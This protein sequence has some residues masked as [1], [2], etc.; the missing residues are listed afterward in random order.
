MGNRA[1]ADEE[2]FHSDP[3][4]RKSESIWKTPVQRFGH[5]KSCHSLIS[6]SANLLEVW[7]KQI[8]CLGRSLWFHMIYVLNRVSICSCVYIY[9][10]IYMYICIHLYI[11]F[12]ALDDLM[13]TSSLWLRSCRDSSWRRS[14]QGVVA[15][16]PQ[17][18]M[19]TGAL[20]DKSGRVWQSLTAHFWRHHCPS[21]FC[22]G[23][24]Y[25]HKDFLSTFQIL[26][27]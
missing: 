14:R 26:Y 7:R 16:C 1:Y 18:Q 5:L 19:G 15:F 17:R 12:V 11:Y 24:I 10:Y 20:D 23:M 6:S 27:Y 3:W 4:L 2:V 13:L 21:S 22:W 8:E 25:S 9:I